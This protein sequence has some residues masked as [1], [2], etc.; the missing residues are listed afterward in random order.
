VGGRRLTHDWRTTQ[1]DFIRT[2]QRNQKAGRFFQRK[3]S[4]F[5][6]AFRNFSSVIHV[7]CSR[8][9]SA[10]RVRRAGVSAEFLMPR[11]MRLARN[12]FAVTGAAPWA[13]RA[14]DPQYAQLPAKD[15]SG[16][17]LGGRESTLNGALMRSIE[18][19]RN[20]LDRTNKIDRIWNCP[21]EETEILL[22]L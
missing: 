8:P 12:T 5:S 18:T 10:A 16:E 9:S 1:L 11:G 3:A 19:L 13:G 17:F 20:G 15:L 7:P 21:E 6:F 22:I 14:R 2:A 4:R